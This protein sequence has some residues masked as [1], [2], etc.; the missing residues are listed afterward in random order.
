M[1]IQSCFFPEF[2]LSLI[3]RE[4]AILK[5]ALDRQQNLFQGIAAQRG[6]SI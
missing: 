1:F 6:L 5:R 2:Q 4:F 3:K